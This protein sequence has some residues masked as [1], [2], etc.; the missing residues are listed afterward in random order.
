MSI[1]P[2]STSSFGGLNH[3]MEGMRRATRLVDEAARG[4]AGGEV[5]SARM[6]DLIKGERMFEANASVVRAQDEMIGALLNVK[7]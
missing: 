7:R 2:P 1:P 6:V 4:I 5:T 3:P